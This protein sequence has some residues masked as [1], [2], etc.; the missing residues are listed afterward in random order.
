MGVAYRRLTSLVRKSA[1]FC[2]CA[3][4]AN[5]QNCRSTKTPE[6]RR[7]CTRKRAWR[8]VNPNLARAT[9]RSAL[10]LLMLQNSG[11]VDGIIATPQRVAALMGRRFVACLLGPTRRLYLDSR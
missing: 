1:L 9:A 5:W 2:P 6:C 8:S 7:T 10:A 4:P 3:M 11:G